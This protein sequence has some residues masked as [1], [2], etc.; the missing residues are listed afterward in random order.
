MKKRVR[1]SRNPYGFHKEVVER[2]QLSSR[3]KASLV[4]RKIRRRF[5]L[6]KCM[7]DADNLE[8]LRNHQLRMPRWKKDAL[9]DL[10][11][12]R[13]KKFKELK[14]ELTTTPKGRIN[15]VCPYCQLDKVGTLDHI[16]PKTP[17]P[18]YSSMPWNLIPCCSTCNSKKDDYWLDEN[19]KRCFINFYIDSIPSVQYFFADVSIVNGKMGIKFELRFPVGYDSVLQ[20]RIEKHYKKL[21]LIKRYLENSDDVIEELE[22]AI[23]GYA[24]GVSDAEIIKSINWTCKK[25]QDRFGVNYWRAVLEMTCVNTPAVFILLKQMK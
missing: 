8:D 23:Q 13:T 7:M 15:N 6:Y 18:E 22:D 16:L 20:T 3:G 25:K 21:G 9:R 19:N 1:Y 4:R 12:Y 17:F 11:S 5:G 14:K 10:Y 2:K 24:S